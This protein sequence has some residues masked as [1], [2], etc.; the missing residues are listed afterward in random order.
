MKSDE[1]SGPTF[2]NLGPKS[3]AA[4]ARVGLY[5]RQDLERVGGVGAY[6]LLREQGFPVSRNM[7]YAIEGALM[8]VDWR[9]LPHEFKLEINRRIAAYEAKRRATRGPGKG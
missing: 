1:R 2:R 6:Q 5:T 7:A 3:M 4:L 8:D 9:A